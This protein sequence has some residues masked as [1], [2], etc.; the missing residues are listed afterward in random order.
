MPNKEL[1]IG[2]QLTANAQFTN[3]LIHQLNT[4]T[5]SVLLPTPSLMRRK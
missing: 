3:F 2:L 4:T 1:G 5:F